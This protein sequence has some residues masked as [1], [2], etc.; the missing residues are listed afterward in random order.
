M[1]KSL[2]PQTTEWLN[3]PANVKTP[4][5]F[6]EGSAHHP[7]GPDDSAFN[8][9]NAWWFM[10][11]ALLTYSSEAAIRG[12][13][14]TAGITGDVTFFPGAHSTQAY[15][16]S[17][18]AA[19]VLAFRGTQVDSFWPS[20]IDFAVDAQFIPVPDGHGGW[21]HG[22]F[23]GAINEVWSE[24]A[25][26][27]RAEQKLTQRPL[28][29][30]GHSLGAGLATLAASRT[31]DDESFGL[32][33]VY[34]YGSPRVGDPDFCRRIR[35]PV[36]RFRNDSDLVAH[37]PLGLVFRH[38]GTSQFIDAAGHLH[39]DLPEPIELMFEP[40][41]HVLSAR[42]AITLEGFLRTSGPEL[43][44]PGF[45]ADHAPINYSILIW[46]CFA[47]THAQLARP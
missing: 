27:V 18:P 39:R 14:N 7:L 35:V 13:F 3:P 5:T 23:L 9:G 10:D 20:V 17:M 45:L 31:C 30:T 11:A 37:L 34:T 16:M 46:N 36:F 2:P 38:V 19:I 47:A 8:L 28:W 43:P 12:A 15:V 33:G 29:I 42:E 21:V 24:I 40:G 26:H 32:Q 41:A 4:Y 44:I 22:G 1:R 6:F 25:T